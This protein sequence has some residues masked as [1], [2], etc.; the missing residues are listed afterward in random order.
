MH[1]LPSSYSTWRVRFARCQDLKQGSIK[2]LI[3]SHYKDEMQPIQVGRP[4]LR[5]R[6]PINEIE[7]VTMCSATMG[8]DGGVEP[9]I[10]PLYIAAA[11]EQMN[12]EVDFRDF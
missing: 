3:V 11:F 12:V 5:Q 8:E 1:S 10:G 9:P 6:R 4:A 7:A 2:E